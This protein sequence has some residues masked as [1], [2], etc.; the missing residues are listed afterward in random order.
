MCRSTISPVL[1]R[2][3]VPFGEFV[4]RASEGRLLRSLK[5]VHVRGI[6]SGILLAV[7]WAE[8]NSFWLIDSVAVDARVVH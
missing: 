8:M 4:E 7:A 1:V 2:P 5:R 3:G 6:K